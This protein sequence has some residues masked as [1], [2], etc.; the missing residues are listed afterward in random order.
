[1]SLVV[2]EGI[3]VSC[4][5]ASRVACVCLRTLHPMFTFDGFEDVLDRELQ[6]GEAV[7]YLVNSGLALLSVCKWLLLESALP[8]T[9]EAD[10][11]ASEL[12]LW[13]CSVFRH[14]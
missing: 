13:F 4:F 12:R 8:T 3:V 14:G 7:R 1:V 2:V 9:L 10:G 6:H 11:G 5:G